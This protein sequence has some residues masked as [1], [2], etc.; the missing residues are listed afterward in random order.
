MII[1]MNCLKY[2]CAALTFLFAA[3]PCAAADFFFKDGDKIVMMGDSITEQHLYSSYVEAWSLTRFP[4]WNLRFFNVGIGGDGAPGGNNRFKRDVLPY[5]ATAITVDFGMNDAGGDYKN[6]MVSLQGIADQTKAAN[7]RVAWCSPQ[8]CENPE[9]KLAIATAGNRNLEKFSEG[10]KQTAAANGSALFIDQFHPF[11]AVIDKARPAN[12]KNRIGGGDQVHPGPPGQTLMAAT[13]L[14]GMN[15]P[16]LVASVEINATS[17]KVVQ[18]RNC[19][20]E[21]LT[22]NADGKIEFKQTDKAL[23]FFPDGDAKNILQWAAILEEMNDYRLKATGLKDGQ[24]EV[25]LGG[26]KVA[27]YSAAAL[28]AGVNLAPAVLTTGPIAD[29]VKAVW[30]AIHAKNQYFHDKIFRGVLLAGGAPEFLG[31]TPEVVEAKREAVFKERMGRMP[32]LFEAIRKT[33]I[34]QSHQVEIVPIQHLVKP[35]V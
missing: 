29:Q 3:L 11:L 2:T 15:F 27:E 35:G 31:M 5:A 10:V 16:A 18:N 25:R 6:F 26:V 9:D 19:A 22:V 28:S 17:R 1:M 30:A 24:Y 12:P 7:I 4:A 14:K 34:M 21:G 20:I 23:P 8:A 33:L 13:I 32:E